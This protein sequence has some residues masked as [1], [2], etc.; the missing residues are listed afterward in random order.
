MATHRKRPYWIDHPDQPRWQ[1]IR[2]VGDSLPDYS[3]GFLYK[4]LRGRYEEEA[5]WIEAPPD[6]K[7]FWGAEGFTRAARW[8]VYQISLERQVEVPDP[9]TGRMLLVPAG[10]AGRD[11]LPN[12]LSSYE[13]WFVEKLPEVARTCGET[14]EA[15]RA[16]FCSEDPFLRFRAYESVALTV[17]WDEFYCY[18]LSLT[19]G[20][21]NRRYRSEFSRMHSGGTL[22]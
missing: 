8:T 6:E 9:T 11:D 15:L 5:D 4:D 16:G 1:A 22:A 7:E 17:G 21:L 19:M 14:V 20:E 10:M 18:P 2:R 3:G 13:E 12:P